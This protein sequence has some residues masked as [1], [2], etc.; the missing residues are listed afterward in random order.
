[1]KPADRPHFTYLGHSTVLCT[2]PDGQTILIDPWV[3]S[4]PSTP[5][6]CHAFQR[7]DAM[8]ITHGHSD[9]M[10]DAVEL[11]K[12]YRPKKVVATFE[13]CHWLSGKGIEHCSGMNIGGCQEVCGCKVTQVPAIHTS[14]IEDG[15]RLLYGGLA[16]GFV[17]SLPGGYTFYHAGDTT[18][19]SDMQLIAELYRPRLAFLPI[20]DFY[21]MDPRQAA[22]ACKLLEVREVVPIHWGTFPELKGTPDAFRRE[23]AS[24]G[25]NCDVISPMP[26]EAVALHS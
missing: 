20:G 14:S 2:L 18:V 7:I 19:F 5:A 8:L 16:S 6:S 24:M 21:T 22:L 26:G 12:R 9:H 25:I 23:L 1:M 3:A 17:V 4:N 10:G 15:D 13:I 11:A